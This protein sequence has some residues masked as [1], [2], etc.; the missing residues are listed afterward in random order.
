MV[1]G[2][3]SH[4]QSVASSKCA[5]GDLRGDQE[6]SAPRLA[7]QSMLDSDIRSLRL[8]GRADKFRQR[9]DSLARQ[10]GQTL[11]AFAIDCRI[12]SQA[13]SGSAQR[14]TFTHLPFSRSL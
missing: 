8:R 5:T 7:W 6:M 13:S 14:D 11:P 2:L 1:F 12:S 3:A 4:D 10:Q 9:L